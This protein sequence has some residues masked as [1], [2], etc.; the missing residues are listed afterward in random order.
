MIRPSPG[1]R[2]EALS[3]PNGSSDDEVDTEYGDVE[4][5]EIDSR[6]S[7]AVPPNSAS[8]GSASFGGSQPLPPP[9]K[10]KEKEWKKTEPDAKR[11][12]MQGLNVDERLGSSFGWGASKSGVE[13][14]SAPVQKA[15]TVPLNGTHDLDDTRHGTSVLS[16]HIRAPSSSAGLGRAS[17]STSGSGSKASISS[18]GPSR[19]PISN[20]FSKFTISDFPP[21][22]S[23][24]S[25]KYR[26]KNFLASIT[27]EPPSLLADAS[28][29]SMIQSPRTSN[30]GRPGPGSGRM[31]PPMKAPP[32][33]QSNLNTDSGM[34]S[35]KLVSVSAPVA[36]SSG[37]PEGS[38]TAPRKSISL[39]E[40]AIEISDD[41]P[42]PTRNLLSMT[43]RKST[44]TSTNEVVN[45]SDED[46]NKEVRRR[47]MGRK[48]TGGNRPRQSDHKL[49]AKASRGSPE[50]IE[51]LD[52]DDEPAPKPEP[53]LR[54]VPPPPV[55]PKPVTPVASS[56]RFPALVAGPLEQPIATT[57]SPGVRSLGPIPDSVTE[58]EPMIVDVKNVSSAS[59]SSY[60]QSVPKSPPPPQPRMSVEDASAAAE[61]E[62]LMRA[63]DTDGG[64]LSQVA[65]PL[66]H[67][68]SS[69]DKGEAMHVDLV[70]S[71]EPYHAPSEDSSSSEPDV[72]FR[73]IANPSIGSP[74]PP[75]VVSVHTSYST[76]PAI[77]TLPNSSI[78][79]SKKPSGS[80]QGFFSI[81]LPASS[82][83]PP[84]AKKHILQMARKGGSAKNTS[85][86]LVYSSESSSSSQQTP[87]REMQSLSREEVAEKD[88]G[89]DMRRLHDALGIDVPERPKTPST[90]PA[91]QTLPV[92]YNASGSQEV[93][94]QPVSP[95][96]PRRT[97]HV[98]PGTHTLVEAL[99]MAGKLNFPKRHRVGNT[100][101]TAIDLTSDPEEDDS[102]SRTANAATSTVDPM[103]KAAIG[104]PKLR[105]SMMNKLKGKGVA[106]ADAISSAPALAETAETPVSDSPPERTP[107]ATEDLAFH[108]SSEHHPTPPESP[109]PQLATPS[110]PFARSPLR[111]SSAVVDGGSEKG[112]LLAE[113]K[114]TRLK[115]EAERRTRVGFSIE[116]RDNVGATQEASSAQETWNLTE[117]TLHA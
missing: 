102:P 80:R 12:R 35:R 117:V 44:T 13:S 38:H 11:A 99:N 53:Q 59:E 110:S 70:T 26:A 30:G 90:P 1:P 22:P 46:T 66:F 84:K 67:A 2:W 25:Q 32:A 62:H 20:A 7:S 43:R 58:E 63:D 105:M 50:I 49:N 27:L 56:S 68:T 55:P 86:S 92:K 95:T 87:L 17:T 3:E 9:R 34:A 108:S 37:G 69:S 109:S 103:P 76:P 8:H 101:E 100:M 54:E 72:R 116:R 29:T 51:I 18:A 83:P 114:M 91:S 10:R 77:A 33:S 14:I 16:S 96:L 31:G 115:P 23:S 5:D 88:A 81:P 65:L 39:S 112:G 106:K 64:R 41:S 97:T 71:V 89:I 61:P 82:P 94:Q 111:H 6:S 98:P 19:Q 4:N 74:I 45:M 93:K 47:S 85:S 42:S 107:P 52:S 28:K 60:R 24:S 73:A 113:S 21:K 79:S 75:E 57:S 15:T 40:E 36:S 48:S 104:S 78:G